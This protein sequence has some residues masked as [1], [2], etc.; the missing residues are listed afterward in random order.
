MFL[1]SQEHEVTA[2]ISQ[3]AGIGGFI[4]RINVPVRLQNRRQLGRERRS[5]ETERLDL[6]NPMQSRHGMGSSNRLGPRAVEGFSLGQDAP[7]RNQR[8]K[9]LTRIVA[10]VPPRIA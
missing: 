9:T 1:R 4:I 5:L 7:T 6:D 2:M 3:V 10:E 8:R